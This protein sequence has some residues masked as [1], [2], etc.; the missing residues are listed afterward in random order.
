MAAPNDTPYEGG[1]YSLDIQ[2]VQEYPSRPPSIYLHTKVGAL[3]PGITRLDIHDA[4]MT[5]P[6]TLA[7]TLTLVQAK[8]FAPPD[9][10]DIPSS[11]ASLHR[12][13]L[14][15]DK[16]DERFENAR[17]IIEVLDLMYRSVMDPSPLWSVE[18]INY[19]QMTFERTK[20]RL[21]GYV[22]MAS[23]FPSS[24]NDWIIPSFPLMPVSDG[25]SE[26]VVGRLK[27]F[28]EL[29]ERGSL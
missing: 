13:G 22:D 2:L 19:F 26:S 1:L 18:M 23:P 8:L 16:K 17:I 27:R 20:Q 4:M 7:N 3:K 5:S 29:I 9:L 14:T 12:R 24:A 6:H 11:A 28:D 21:N 15:K 25:F 10:M